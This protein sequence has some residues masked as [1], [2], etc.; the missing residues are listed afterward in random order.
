VHEGELPLDGMR[1]E[2]EEETGRVPKPL[3]FLGTWNEPYF[4]RVVLCLTWLALLD[5]DVRA[6]DDLAELRWF[7]P[8]EL[9]W[10]ELAFLHYTPALR[11]ALARQQDVQRLRRDS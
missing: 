10:D 6:A 2:V 11:L 5:T 7:P 3:E 4:D 1:R 8:D 9:P